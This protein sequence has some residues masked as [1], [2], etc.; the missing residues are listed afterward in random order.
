MP[1]QG[2]LAR[3]RGDA[4]ALLGVSG[5]Y[6]RGSSEN[7]QLSRI[8]GAAF[9]NKA[10]LGE[11]LRFL[12]RARQHDNRRLGRELELFS[13]SDA[14]GSGLPLWLPKGTVVRQQLE[15]SRIEAERR[16]CYQHIVTPQLAKKSIYERSGH[17]AHYHLS[18]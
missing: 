8:A 12:E 13:I 5:A 18:L 14:I 4:I 7:P 1:G 11:R 15:Q 9:D 10:D 16:Q 3:P 6:W 17:W 2:L